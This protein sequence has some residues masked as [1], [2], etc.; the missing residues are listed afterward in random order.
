M[1]PVY[2]SAKS[3]REQLRAGT[4]LDEFNRLRGNFATELSII[5][6]RMQAKPTTARL[7]QT[8]FLAYEG[9]LDAYSLVGEVWTYRSAM[10]ACRGKE[11]GYAPKS[12]PLS[13]RTRKLELE[14]AWMEQT[15][16]CVQSAEEAARKLNERSEHLKTQCGPDVEYHLDCIVKSAE[17]R[18]TAADALLIQQ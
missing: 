11:P 3:L 14:G 15:M 16:K 5:R 7:L 2:R 8:Y 17:S 13:E 1:E 12:A 4:S 6:D 9:A 10:D 18:A